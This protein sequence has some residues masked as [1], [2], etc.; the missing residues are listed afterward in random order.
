MLLDDPGRFIASSPG[1]PATELLQCIGIRDNY[2]RFAFDVRQAF[3]QAPSE[4]HEQSLVAY[5]RK[6]RNGIYKKK[7]PVNS[8]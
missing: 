6:V 5:I 8:Y 3:I 2:A 1:L 7:G 4:P